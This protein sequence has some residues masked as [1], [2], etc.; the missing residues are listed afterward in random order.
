MT[1]TATPTPPTSSAERLSAAMR[2]GSRAE[3]EAAEGS[4]FM[5]GLL[6]GRLDAAAYAAYL[7]RLRVVYTTMEEACRAHLDDPLVRAVH[8]PALE[9]ADAIDADLDHWAPS[10]A[11]V[12]TGSPAA[13]AYRDRLLAAR[14]EAAAGWGGALVAHHYTRYLG[15]LSGG[16]AIGRLLDRAYDLDGSGTAFYAFPAITKPKVYKDHYRARLDGLRL[17]PADVDR[18]VEEVKAAFRLNQ[19]LL[20]ELGRLVLDSPAS[21]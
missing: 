20:A 4:A 17:A 14:D 18:V 8:D 5:T 16:Q 21:A 13:D 1:T 15:D 10:L 6:D 3:H 11:R 12:V 7:L 2:D 19:Q 9:R